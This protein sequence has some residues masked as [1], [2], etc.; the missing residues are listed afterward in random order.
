MI[1]R[2]G[3]G[4]ASEVEGVGLKGKGIGGVEKG[5]VCVGVTACI[6]T[7][8]QVEE[9]TLE[10]LVAV[11]RDRCLNERSLIVGLSTQVSAN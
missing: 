10:Q 5:R 7:T 11:V 3:E 1:V 6:K 4:Q 2:E 8:V 9:Q